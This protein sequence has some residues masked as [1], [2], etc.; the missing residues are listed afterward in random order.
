MSL[1]SIW[2]PDNDNLNAFHWKNR[3]LLVFAPNAADERLTRQTKLIQESAAGFEDRD[4]R[5]FLVSGTEQSESDLRSRFHISRDA[6]TVVL[7]GK[8]GTEKMRQDS[9]LQPQ[10]LFRL[11][12]S[13]PMRRAGAR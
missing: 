7:I 8:D 6:Y 10:K 11:V 9:V 1:I 5:V 12:D 4:F 2:S 13:M 3:I